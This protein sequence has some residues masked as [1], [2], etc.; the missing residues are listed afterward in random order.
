MKL[1]FLEYL[2]LLFNC[3]NI[4][5]GKKIWLDYIIKIF[6]DYFSFVLK[7]EFC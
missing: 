4:N 6:F 7:W 3:N 1:N 2:Y 5:K